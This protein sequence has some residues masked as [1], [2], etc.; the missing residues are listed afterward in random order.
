MTESIWFS[1]IARYFHIKIASF[2]AKCYWFG[3]VSPHLA[4]FDLFGSVW[5]CLAISF[6]SPICPFLV[7]FGN[8]MTRFV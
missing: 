2:I 7:P 4:P 6:F 5:L 8:G 1:L 3:F